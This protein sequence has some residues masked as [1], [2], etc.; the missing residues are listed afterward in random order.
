MRRR[1]YLALAGGASATALS[2]CTG[3]LS[4]GNGDTHLSAPDR[5][6]DAEDLPYPAHGAKLPSVE[7]SAPL[8]DETISTT[9]FDDRDVVMT[10]IYTH[11]NTMCPRLTS[12]LRNVQTHSVNNG[13]ADDVAFLAVSFDPKR[14]TEERFRT[15]AE[16][17]NVDLDAGNWYF[18]RPESEQRAKEVVQETFGVAFEKTH[19]ENMDMYMFTHS[20][21]V[22]LANRKGYVERAY[23]ETSDGSLV[24]QDVRDDLNKVRQ[25]ES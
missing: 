19:P 2:G 3:M 9:Q 11:C 12:A 22:L 7:L 21:V 23:R 18:L 13:Y 16:E 10:F 15:Y 4:S 1:Q 17:M 14:D 20:G 8:H 25:A 24:W 6:Y 5:E